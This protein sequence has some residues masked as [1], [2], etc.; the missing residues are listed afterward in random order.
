DGAARVA[1]HRFGRLRAVRQPRR[2]SKIEEVLERHPPRNGLE[3]REASD[4]RRGAGRPGGTEAEGACEGTGGEGENVGDGVAV[5]VAGA[6]SAGSSVARLRSGAIGCRRSAWPPRVST[7]SPAT[8]S[9]TRVTA[10]RFFARV[11]AS[12]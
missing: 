11:T 1:P 7:A 9:T 6:S 5:G 10:G 2:V 3:H 12:A 4:P 8:R